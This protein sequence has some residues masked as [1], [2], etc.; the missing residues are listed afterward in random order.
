MRPTSKSGPQKFYLG[1][2]VLAPL[3][4]WDYPLIDPIHIVF[5]TT[6]SLETFQNAM[7]GGLKTNKDTDVYTNTADTR[8]KSVC[9]TRSAVK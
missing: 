8:I 1:N 4:F 2:C 6:F 3:K 5:V 9:S 7:V